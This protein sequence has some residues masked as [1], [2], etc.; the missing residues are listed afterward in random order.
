M[1]EMITLNAKSREEI[2]PG[3]LRRS[4]W[5]PGVIYGRDTETS[6][7]QF[8]TVELRTAY[9]RAG[10]N[11]IVNLRI[12]GADAPVMALF[13]EVQRDPVSGAFL[14]ADLYKVV[15]GQKVTS[16]VPIVLVGSAPATMLGGSVSQLV[17]ELEIECLPQDLPS[18]IT[19][20]ISSLVDLHS[21]IA[22][23]D[24]DIPLGVTVL[25]PPDTDIVRVHV[26][27][28]AE[29]AAAEAPAGEAAGGTAGA[30]Q[31]TQA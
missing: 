26:Q 31:S 18:A 21:A 14:H 10:T 7:L 4:G 28:E 3:A 12:E 13:R 23:S 22:Y 6:S 24:L 1:A 17:S 27:R 8:P 25:N 15:A 16:V 9:M 2:K 30:A 29:E 5:V 19:V 11:R 20:D